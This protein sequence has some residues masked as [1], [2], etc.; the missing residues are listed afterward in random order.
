MTADAPRHERVR[1][2]CVRP[3]E[4]PHAVDERQCSTEEAPADEQALGGNPGDEGEGLNF[5]IAIAVELMDRGVI[6]NYQI[7]TPS[8]FM[9]SPKDPFGNPG[10]Y[11]EAVMSTPLLENYEKPEDFKGI[12]V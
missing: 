8:T 9:A 3:L 2:R 11:E 5:V 10:P 1:N 12:D 4:D 7:L 6:E